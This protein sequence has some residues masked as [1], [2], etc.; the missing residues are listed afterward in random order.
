M[1]A[2]FP[3]DSV[4]LD[5]DLVKSSEGAK[6]TMVRVGERIGQFQA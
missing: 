6:E 4:S 3:E 2:V 1:I 5:S